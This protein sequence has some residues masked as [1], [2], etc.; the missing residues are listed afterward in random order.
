[1]EKKNYIIKM[2]SALLLFMSVMPGRAAKALEDDLWFCY[3]FPGTN[4]QTPTANTAYRIFLESNEA[5]FI[6]FAYQDDLSDLHVNSRDYEFGIGGQSY[7]SLLEDLLFN[8][9]TNGDYGN[10]QYYNATTVP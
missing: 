3:T 4:R 9:G 8:Y 10:E 1:M 2:A 5:E 6:G 7:K